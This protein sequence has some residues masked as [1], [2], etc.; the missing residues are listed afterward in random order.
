MVCFFSHPLQYSLPLPQGGK[1]AKNPHLVDDQHFPQ[2]RMSRKA[3][4]KTNVFDPDY[5]A[6][7]SPFSEHDVYSRSAGLQLR[8]TQTRGGRQRSNPNAARKKFVKKWSCTRTTCRIWTGRLKHWILDGMNAYGDLFEWSVQ[9]SL[10]LNS[11]LKNIFHVLPLY[12]FKLWYG[13]LIFVTI[14]KDYRRFHADWYRSYGGKNRTH[15]TQY[16]EFQKYQKQAA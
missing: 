1:H 12:Q 4:Q 10:D 13:N 2:Q 5:L 9:F 6:G 14:R 3:R 7:S 8:D 11:I 16:K 15:L